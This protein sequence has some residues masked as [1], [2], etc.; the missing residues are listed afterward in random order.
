MFAQ[1]QAQHGT[2]KSIGYALHQRINESVYPAS[3]HADHGVVISRDFREH[4]RNR[5]LCVW[6]VYSSQRLMFL[7]TENEVTIPTLLFLAQLALCREKNRV[8]QMNLSVIR[9]PLPSCSKDCRVSNILKMI[10][11]YHMIDCPCANHRE[12]GGGGTRKNLQLC[13][14][15]KSNYHPPTDQHTFIVDGIKYMNIK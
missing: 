3:T 13:L 5:C 15:V 9:D 11:V 2:G 12:G 6:L 1:L 14:S 4:G 7:K 10:S 8:E